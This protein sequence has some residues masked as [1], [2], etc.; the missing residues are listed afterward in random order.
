M[1]AYPDIQILDVMSPLEVF[2][3]TT[4]WPTGLCGGRAALPSLGGGR[5][6]MLRNVAGD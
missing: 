2:A 4:R 5:K 1:L 6:C 3:R